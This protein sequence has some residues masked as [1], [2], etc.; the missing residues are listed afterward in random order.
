MAGIPSRRDWQNKARDELQRAWKEDVSLKALI[1]ACPGAGKTFF[2]ALETRS[3]FESDSINL[4]IIVVPTV[5][6]QLQWLEDLKAVGLN[7]CAEIPNE[8]L[9]WRKDQGLSMIEDKQ[10]IVITYHQL[11][12]DPELF[13]EMARRYGNAMV[14]ADEVH[15]ADDD[16]TFGDALSLLADAAKYRLALSGTPFNS[17]GGALAMCESAEEIDPETGRPIRR[18]LATFS[19]SYGRAITD[20]VC[21][22]VEF[23]KVLGRGEATYRLLNDNSTYT[24]I[25][26]LA[27]K[28]RTDRLNVLLDPEGEFMEECARQ[29]IRS[30]KAMRAAGD[31]KAGMLVV[32]KNKAHGARMADLIDRLCKAE[33][34]SFTI[35]E[36]Y[37]DSHKAHDRIEELQKDT[38]DIVVS[39]RM[40]SE[41]VDVKRLRVGLFAT[42]WMTRM[43]FIQFIGRFVRM[44][45]RLDA[46]QYAA[47]VI[48]AHIQLLEYAFEIEKMVDSAAIVE[49]ADTGEAEGPPRVSELLGIESEAGDTGIVYRG[50]E[51]NDR[52]LADAFFEQC[53]SLRGCITEMAAIKAAKD[54]GLEGASPHEGPRPI[55]IDWN[56]RNTLMARA[57]VKR[58][59]AN[60]ESDDILF[61]KVNGSANR[62]AGIQK[63]DKLTPTDALQRR[64]K[65]LQ[66]W[67]LRLYRGDHS[68]GIGSSDAE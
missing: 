56:T 60:G 10:V 15:H 40:I 32:A 43:F 23:I 58:L 55:D 11:S 8:N 66:D 67:M 12:R 20:K 57:V 48:P 41:G 62:A 28:R 50:E 4:G 65:Y 7:A 1:A 61:A 6:I 9:R 30:L 22:P 33:D 68:D 38:T 13:E 26:D 44:E 31:R 29:S 17:T 42:D 25:T 37:N 52:N 21:R 24:R 16:K 3:L 5:N 53:P 51:S 2:S 39:V 46:T 18:T 34:A 59:R 36:I 47:V 64:H 49:D 19:Y 14:I 63:M 45:D 35:Q 27:R 54:M